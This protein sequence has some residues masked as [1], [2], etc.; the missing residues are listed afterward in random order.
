MQ[1]V[2]TKTQ[3]V[4]VSNNSR[5]E[6]QF[7]RLTVEAGKYL[8][9]SVGDSIPTEEIL[10]QARANGYE[11]RG[12]F[13]AW[14]HMDKLAGVEEVELPPQRDVLGELWKPPEPTLIDS[15]E[16]VKHGSLEQFRY[17]CSERLSNDKNHSYTRKSANRKYAKAKDIDRHFVKNYDEF[18]T[19]LITYSLPKSGETPAAHAEEYYPRRITRRRRRILKRNNVYDGYAGISLLAPY[20]PD[21]DIP[22]PDAPT[23]HAHDFIWVQDHVSKEMFGSLQNVDGFNVNISVENHVSSEIT[24]PD[25]V[26]AKGSGLDGKRG[27]TTKLPHEL[28]DNLPCLNCRMD[29]R[30]T[31]DYVEEWCAALRAGTDG[32][33]SSRGVSRFTKLGCFEEASSSY[34]L[35][36]ELQEGCRTGKNLLS[37]LEYHTP[38]DPN[39]NSSNSTDSK[40]TFNNTSESDTNFTFTDT[41]G[42]NESQFNLTSS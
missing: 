5:R 33:F 38:L 20:K 41:N 21:D 37:Y 25:R 1:S 40:F 36:R 8:N 26:K 28:A 10:K 29:A 27:D 32:S 31:P 11:E 39:Q 19:A 6:K 9:K 22:Y 34:K 23:T 7:Y 35:R 13:Y 42:S 24:T 4:K 2:K 3:T 16:S 17:W 12:R 30:G 18:S 14:L 15:E